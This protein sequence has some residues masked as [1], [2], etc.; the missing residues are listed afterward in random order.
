MPS[1]RSEIQP[2][3]EKPEA[4]FLTDPAA[5]L[6]PLTAL[7]ATRRRPEGVRNAHR[8]MRAAAEGRMARRSPIEVQATEPGR[9][10]V[11]DGNSTF[12]VAVLSG[13]TSIPCLVRPAGGD[14][15]PD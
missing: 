10:R 4:Y 13:W 6:L 12:A 3:P 9:W 14:F 8:Y 11:I 1:H 15:L 5:I 7:D 2:L